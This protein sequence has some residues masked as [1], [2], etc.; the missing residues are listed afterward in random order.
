MVFGVSEFCKG[1]PRPLELSSTVRLKIPIFPDFP[2]FLLISFDF[3][4]FLKFPF[5][6]GANRPHGLSTT[7]G[8]ILVRLDMSSVHDRCSCG[9]RGKWMGHVVT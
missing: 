6:C 1:G 9:R 8:C 2:R 4:I 3:L 7:V 5:L